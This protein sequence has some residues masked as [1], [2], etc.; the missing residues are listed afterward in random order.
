DYAAP[1][2]APVQLAHAAF[3]PSKQNLFTPLPPPS[4]AEDQFFGDLAKDIRLRTFSPGDTIIQEGDPAKCVFFIFR[5]SVEVVSADGEL[6]LSALDAG[7]Y[8]GEIA[9]LFETTR[10]ATVR[11]LSKCLLGVLTSADLHVHLTKYPK[12]KELVLTEARERYARSK[13]VME[14]SG[15]VAPSLGH[16]TLYERK[17]SMIDIGRS[18]SGKSGLESPAVRRSSSLGITVSL[19]S[20]DVLAALTQK[21]ASEPAAVDDDDDDDEMLPEVPCIQINPE[22]PQI[23]EPLPELPSAKV[24]PPEPEPAGGSVAVWSDENLMKVAQNATEKGST[25]SSTRTS[26]F[27]GPKQRPTSLRETSEISIDYRPS[28]CEDEKRIFSQFPNN[29]AVMIL[30]YFDTRFLIKLRRAIL[31]HEIKILNLRNCWQ[32]TDKGLHSI[33]QFCSLLE[34]INLA[35]HIQLSYCKNLTDAIHL[36]D[37]ILS[38][39]S[40]LTDAAVTNIAKTCPQLQLLSLSFCCALTEECI[41]PLT[42]GCKDLHTCLSKLAQNSKRLERLSVR[43]CVLI[44]NDGIH[45][46]KKGLSGLKKVNMTQCRNVKFTKEELNGFGW[47]ILNGG[48]LALDKWGAE[49]NVGSPSRTRALT[50]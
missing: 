16:E 47:V 1:S 43:G 46:L 45:L 36:Q 10:V 21:L 37:L 50:Q 35:S 40:F 33:S 3:S 23:L 8:F 49:V 31:G 32:V 14:N 18:L 5:G 15:K 24:K 34:F 11:C 30:R 28:T 22:H 17:I 41:E 4:D 12:M 20:P 6:V 48:E 44:T 9:V 39:C 26:A 25:S 29:L 19:P 13:T 42:L 7:S 27:S 38:D 2:S